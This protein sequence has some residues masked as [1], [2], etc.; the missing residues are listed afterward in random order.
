VMA[1]GDDRQISQFVEKPADPPSMPGRPD[2]SL[3]SM[4]IYIFNAQYLYDALAR[5]V[6]DPKSSHDF[7]RDIVPRAVKEGVALA[8]PF[9][10]SCV[11]TEPD[12]EPY[13]RDV[14]TIDA[15]WEANIDLTATEPALNLYDTTW[16][17]STYQEQLPSA[18]FVHN[19]GERRGMA[20]ESMVSGG[21]IISGAQVK[22]SLLFSG[23]R[24]NSY[25]QTREAVLLPEVHVG[26]YARLNKVVVDRGCQIPENL[27]I[28]EDPVLDAKRF[29]RS[30]GGVVLVSAEMLDGL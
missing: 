15:Y 21:C 26:R 11:R 18:K 9:G 29:Y 2:V 8:H 28:G 5:D 25:A 13:W 17:I 27:V 19:E 30:D 14:G 10:L 6:A 3:A 16:P 1:V 20:I 22:S 24:V 4:G 23:V 12:K 7:G